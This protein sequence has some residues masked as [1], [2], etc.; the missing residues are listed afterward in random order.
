[1]KTVYTHAKYTEWLSAYDMH[2]ESKKWLSEL[3]FYKEEQWFFEDLIR[4]YTLQILDNDH[5]E[6]SKALIERLTAIVKQTQSLVNSVKL[7]EKALSIMV[8]GIDQLEEENAY[9]KEH[10]Q[11]LKRFEIFKS[12]YLV[13]KSE[14]FSLIKTVMKASKQK[15]LLNKK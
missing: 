2:A 3:E 1:M 13:L 12:R 5:F 7:H 9:R 11:L 4:S 6:K 8:D 14:F 15:R 10:R